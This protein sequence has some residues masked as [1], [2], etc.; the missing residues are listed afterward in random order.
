MAYQDKSFTALFQR[1]LLSILLQDP[2]AYS[3][4]NGIWDHSYFDDNVHRRIAQA[5]L[6]IRR[7]GHDHPNPVSLLQSLLGSYDLRAMPLDAQALEKE[8]NALY[9][10]P[11]QN[12]SF[13]LQEVRDWAINHAL[14]G[15]L[16]QAI[17]FVN[18]GQHDKVRQVIDQALAIGKDCG[19]SGITVTPKTEN[20]CEILFAEKEAGL[21]LGLI[22]LD[23]RLEGGL[24]PGEMLTFLGGPGSFKSGTMLNCM[25]RALKPDKARNVTYISLEMSERQVYARFCYRITSR[26]GGVEAVDYWSEKIAK[27][28]QPKFDEV[29]KKKIQAYSGSLHIKTFGSNT[30]DISGLRAYLDYLDG[31]GHETQLLIVDYPGIMLRPGNNRDDIEMGLLY[32]GVRAIGIDRKIPVITAAQS[33]RGFLEDPEKANMSHIAATMDIARTSD[34]IVAIIQTPEEKQQKKMRFKLIKNRNEETGVLINIDVDYPMC[35]I[36]DKGEAQPAEQVQEETAS[37]TVYANKG[38]RNGRR[39]LEEKTKDNLPTPEE[40][41]LRHEEYL[42]TRIK[43]R[44]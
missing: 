38:S 31:T 8:V 37:K 26:P 7:G 3:R 6:E 28:N 20:P 42:A 22:S 35:F 12:V 14:V 40:N 18:T 44:S 11:L 41:R 29:F 9:A 27:G 2:T 17:D 36:D 21:P 13:S 34:Y 24:R 15:S 39:A 43:G 30:L 19:D 16:S 33:T 10:I 1:Q 32:S 4:F 25:I 23:T 5:Y